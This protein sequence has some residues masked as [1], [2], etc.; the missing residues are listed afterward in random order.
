MTATMQ[1]FYFN[2]GRRDKDN[3]GRCL[4]AFESRGRMKARTLLHLN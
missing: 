1:W 2:L 3:S 4:V